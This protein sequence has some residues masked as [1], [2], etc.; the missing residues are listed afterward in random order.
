[1]ESSENEDESDGN[2]DIAVSHGEPD[3]AEHNSTIG[4]D[5]EEDDI[6]NVMEASGSQPKAKEEICRW[7]ELREQIKSDLEEAHKRHETLTHMNKLL[8]LRNFATLRIK[9]TRQI[10]ASKEIAQQW[11]KGTGVHFAR[12]IR[13]LA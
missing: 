2:E 1:V 6:D 3:G 9:G 8:I 11:H 7:E 13:F 10:N 5:N 4:S 12:Q